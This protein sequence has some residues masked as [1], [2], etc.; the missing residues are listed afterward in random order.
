MNTNNAD[1]APNLTHF[2]PDPTLSP[3]PLGVRA[4]LAN[5][6]DSIKWLTSSSAQ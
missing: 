5:I 2:Y 3:Q 4:L 6:C 1:P